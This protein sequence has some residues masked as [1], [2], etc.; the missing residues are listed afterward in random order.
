MEGSRIY[1]VHRKHYIFIIKPPDAEY[2]LMG[3]SGIWGPYE[4]KNLVNKPRSPV[5]ESGSPHQGGIVSMP[6]GKWM[7]VS[8]I[9][10]YPGGRVPVIAPVNWDSQGWPSIQGGNNWGKT[11]SLPAGG[12]GL[13]TTRTHLIDTFSR[14]QPGSRMGV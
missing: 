6:D 12:P 1:K 7:Y 11:Y 13:S 4:M 8:F 5:P 10:A 3:N 14:C 9:D 2:A